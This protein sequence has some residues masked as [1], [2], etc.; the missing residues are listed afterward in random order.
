MMSS[1]KDQWNR[2]HSETALQAYVLI[3]V[4]SRFASVLDFLYEPFLCI[5]LQES[6]MFAQLLISQIEFCKASNRDTKHT[7]KLLKRRSIESYTITSKPAV[8]IV[9][10]IIVLKKSTR[11]YTLDYTGR[12]NLFLIKSEIGN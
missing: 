1:A 9:Y 12:R 10:F 8:D 3:T 2:L 6:R 11:V 5:L 7:Q 4:K